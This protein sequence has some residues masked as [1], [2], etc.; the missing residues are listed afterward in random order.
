MPQ[1]HDLYADVYGSNFDRALKLQQQILESKRHDAEMA[2]TMRAHRA[3]ELIQ[4]MHYLQTA[5]EHQ[6]GILSDAQ[7]NY[8]ANTANPPSGEA[9]TAPIGFSATGQSVGGEPQW[10]ARANALRARYFTEHTDE[11]PG[12]PIPYIGGQKGEA[13]YLNAAKS[14]AHHNIDPNSP[15][16]QAARLR[17]LKDSTAQKSD[18]SPKV[19]GFKDVISSAGLPVDD[20]LSADNIWTVNNSG[21]D[22]ATG[23]AMTAIDPKTSKPY[24]KGAAVPAEL[25]DA[26]AYNHPQKGYQEFPVHFPST[27]SGKTMGGPA[28]VIKAYNEL[29]GRGKVSPA[30]GGSGPARV[31]SVKEAMGLPSGTIFVDPSGKTRKVP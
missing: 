3:N 5:R 24:A 17:Y 26:I 11:R 28:L 9:V 19:K 10:T 21:N 13:Q 18:E 23:Q 20:I 8:T 22:P 27:P 4:Q 25:A 1:Y 29:K 16:G 31:S 30:P 6:A 14:P 2:E 7:A 15:E 12:P